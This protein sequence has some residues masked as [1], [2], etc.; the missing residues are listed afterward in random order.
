MSDCICRIRDYETLIISIL[1]NREYYSV[2]DI[3]EL[4]CAYC[5]SDK[6]HIVCALDSLTRR[7]ILLREVREDLGFF[8]LLF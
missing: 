6:F 2:I 1:L 3:F 4:C 7:G 8:K 5:E